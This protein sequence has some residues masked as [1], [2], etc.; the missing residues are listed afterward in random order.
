MKRV[1]FSYLGC[2]D[3]DAVAARRDG[4]VEIGRL[5]IGT[6][7][8]LVGGRTQ[9]QVDLFLKAC[10][11]RA[12]WSGKYS[13]CADITNAIYSLAGC[14]DERFIN[15]DDDDWDGVPD[16]KEQPTQEWFEEP[17]FHPWKMGWNVTMFQNGA[18]AVGA[19]EG[20]SYS[21]KPGDA[22]LE[23]EDGAEHVGFIIDTYID[24][25][26]NECHI[27]VEGGQVDSGGQCV[28]VYARTKKNGCLLRAGRT[29][30]KKLI[31]YVNLE[32]LPLK[33]AA[34]VP[35]DCAFGWEIEEK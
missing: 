13:T 11:G 12:K 25:E 31:G 15:R 34:M 7:V 5:F 17:S 22:F 19:W 18:K 27:C 1:Y 26:G 4:V 10:E 2:P 20:P 28:L 3:A 21:G 30:G 35:D 32:K 9:E 23:G 8:G 33:A 24:D 14:R 6:G 16:D 29:T